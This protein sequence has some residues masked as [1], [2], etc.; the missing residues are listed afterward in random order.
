MGNNNANNSAN[1]P[2]GVG[3]GGQQGNL[4]S[5]NSPAAGQIVRRSSRLFG[6]SQSSVKENSSKAPTKKAKNVAGGPKSSPSRKVKGQ[7]TALSNSAE[8]A[9]KNEKNKTE[10]EKVTTAPDEAIADD[11]KPKQNAKSTV[12]SVV[13]SSANMGFTAATM[14]VQALA[15]QKESVGGLMTLMNQL[16]QAYSELCRYDSNKALKRLDELPTIHR[17]TAWV[18]GLAGKAHFENADYKAAKA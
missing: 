18:I 14:S 7:R 11:L 10:K 1:V 3:V 2:A 15:I 5:E 6:S 4:N 16:G 8:L 17:N 9:E 12:P 13:T